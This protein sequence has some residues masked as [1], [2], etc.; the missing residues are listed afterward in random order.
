ME[1]TPPL[2]SPADE[3]AEDFRALQ[4]K[5]WGQRPWQFLGAPSKQMRELLID[6]LIGV[7][8]DEFEL[9]QGVL[10]ESVVML[11]AV[12]GSGK[13]R[14][15]A[16]NFQLVGCACFWIAYKFW[17]DEDDDNVNAAAIVDVADDAFTPR[18]LI[19]MEG[20][21]LEVIEWRVG[22][23]CCP[24]THWLQD[25]L[26]DYA[27]SVTVVQQQRCDQ[28]KALA[29][30]CVNVSLLDPK[31]CYLEQPP[32]RVAQTC[33]TLSRLIVEGDDD[34]DDTHCVA[35]VGGEHIIDD[36]ITHLQQCCDLWRRVRTAQDYEYA[37]L[38]FILKSFDFLDDAL[39]VFQQTEPPTKKRLK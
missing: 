18:K 12:C 10:H 5:R 16:H 3:Y 35:N 9:P 11:D 7:V 34:D 20:K 32:W 2:S 4:H 28:I 39:R 14:V 37:G 25:I 15:D 36:L 1:P 38:K 31:L 23:W 29:N 24:A 26:K 8:L 13:L 21:V 19:A 33:F 22:G 6:W 27:A 30:A 17:V